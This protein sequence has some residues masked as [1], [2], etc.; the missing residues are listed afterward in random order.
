MKVTSIE[1]FVVKGLTRP[2]LFCAIHTD[3]GITGYS[4]FGQGQM[5]NGMC[6]LVEDL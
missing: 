6:G 2:W 3:E 4:E 5:A 1:T